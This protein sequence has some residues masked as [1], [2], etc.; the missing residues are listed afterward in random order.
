[1]C[2]PLITCLW[3][4][5][6]MRSTLSTA[7]KTF[8][9]QGLYQWNM[10]W[11]LIE[12]IP[13]SLENRNLENNW[14]ISIGIPFRFVPWW[15]LRKRYD[16]NTI[17]EKEKRVKKSERFSRHCGIACDTQ[18]IKTRMSKSGSQFHQWEKSER[19]AIFFNSHTRNFLQ[20]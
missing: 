10:A 18:M 17:R 15:M 11:I 6:W 5:R 13:F 2:T 20:M 16:V 19:L 1:M 3:L 8:T 7:K 4:S 9:D 14:I 12:I